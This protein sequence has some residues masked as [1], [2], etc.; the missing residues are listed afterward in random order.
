MA[1]KNDDAQ[2]SLTMAQELQ[3]LL[4]GPDPADNSKTTRH[5]L[6]EALIE[7]AKEGNIKALQWVYKV[8]GEA[9]RENQRTSIFKW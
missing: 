9:Q 5:A 6:C 2:E 7:Q 1:R 4:D 3:N 8:A